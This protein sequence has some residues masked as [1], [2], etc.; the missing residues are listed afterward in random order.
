MPSFECKKKIR[1]SICVLT[2]N[3]EKYLNEQLDSIIM[4]LNPEDEIIILDNNSSD[5]TCLIIEEYAK[6][7]NVVPA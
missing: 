4:Q 7:H 3:A 6:E 5:A 2:F 1:A